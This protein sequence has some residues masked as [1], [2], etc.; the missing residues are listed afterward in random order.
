MRCIAAPIR[1]DAGEV[2]AAIG[3]AGPVS[4]LSKKALASFMPH[5]VGTAAAISARLGHRPRAAG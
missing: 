3:I 4:R 1:N 5:V 2:V